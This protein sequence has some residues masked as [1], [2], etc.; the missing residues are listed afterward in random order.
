M[1]KKSREQKRYVLTVLRENG[2]YEPLTIEEMDQFE[3]ENP[4]IAKIW[5]KPGGIQTLEVNRQP[6]DGSSGNPVYESWDIAA[7]RL[8]SKLWKTNSAWI[9]HQP[10][11]TNKLEIPDYHQVITHPMDFGTI[12]NKLNSN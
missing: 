6:F 8:M 4:E 9:F 11:D 12:R 5:L 10:V 3:R 1:E 2:N 7:K